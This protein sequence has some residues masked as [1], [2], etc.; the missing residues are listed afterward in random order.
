MDY[1]RIYKAVE[2]SIV[3]VVIFDNSNQLVSTASGAIIDNGQKVLTCAHCCN[4]KLNTGIYDKVNAKAFKGTIIFDDQKND[5]AVI[6][7]PYR[8]GKPLKIVK[9][10]FLEIGNEVFTVGYP[11]VFGSE[12]T[13]TVGNI[14]A[15]ENGMIKINTSVNNGNSGGPL[16]NVSGEIVGVVNAKLG[17]LS[18]FLKTVEQQRPQAYMVI[19]G[20]NP[21]QIIQ[22]MIREMQQNLNLGIGYAIP[23]SRIASFCDFVK[24]IMEC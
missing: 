21:V 6:E 23:S 20:M 18:D 22:Q 7:F 9:S 8:I 1:S 13:L 14:A 11:Y 17:S 15:F 24:K 3:N 4:S 10:D 5:I 19:D 2:E 16:F 12:K